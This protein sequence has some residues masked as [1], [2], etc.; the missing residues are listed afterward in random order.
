MGRVHAISCMVGGPAWTAAARSRL[1]SLDHA[2]VDIGLHL[3][4]TELPLLP[5]AGPSLPTLI[6]AGLL[7]RLD[8]HTVRAEIRAQLDA[9]EQTLGRAPAFVDGHRHVHQLAGVRQE[10]LAELTDRYVAARPWLRSTR[11]VRSS[12]PTGWRET[13]K[14]RV[15]AMLGARGLAASAERLDFA[16]NRHLL[17]V[18]DF[19]GGAGRYRQ[20]L[21][22]WLRAA[23]DADLLMCHPSARVVSN[24]PLGE[25]RQA[26]FSVLA[27]DEF[28]AMRH[29]AAVT[30]APMRRILSRAVG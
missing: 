18:Y 26:E 23:G 25:A 24:D 30:L 9:F 2:S 7:G 22:F 8:T 3:D 19:R 27:G 5:G 28:G 10:V 6:V 11:V 12:A 14:A 16:Q 4:F 17:G 29:S 21:A 13:I 20:L 1:R 15:I